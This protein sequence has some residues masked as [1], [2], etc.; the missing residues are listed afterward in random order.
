MSF[1]VN[2]KH[3]RREWELR[4]TRPGF[5]NRSSSAWID[6]RW[7]LSVFWCWIAYLHFRNTAIMRWFIKIPNLNVAQMGYISNIFLS[8]SFY[9]C[10]VMISKTHLIVE[11]K[12]CTIVHSFPE[13]KHTWSLCLLKAAGW[14]S[15]VNRKEE[16]EFVDSEINHPG[17]SSSSFNIPY[18]SVDQSHSLVIKHSE[19]VL[20]LLHS[21]YTIILPARCCRSS[22]QK[23]M[24]YNGCCSVLKQARSA[25]MSY[26]PDPT[27]RR[28]K[29]DDSRFQI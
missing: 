4:S 24:L 27:S 10:C 16:V 23:M 28:I 26:L 21:R 2:P 29:W 17:V 8:S 12:N 11:N 25:K 20:S 19:S 1:L 6:L 5:L 13:R 15:W 22:Y 14:I 9:L 3:D 7:K 18:S